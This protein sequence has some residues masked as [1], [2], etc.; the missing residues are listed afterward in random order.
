VT[1]GV[2][3]ACN[4]CHTDRDARWAAAQVRAHYPNPNPGFQRF[5]ESFAADDRRDTHAGDSLAAIAND[6]TQPAIV[7]GS[8]IARLGAPVLAPEWSSLRKHLE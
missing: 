7:R 4:R 5:A 2:P 3:N 1:L 6:A 8:A